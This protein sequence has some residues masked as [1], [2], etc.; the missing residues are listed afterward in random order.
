MRSEARRREVWRRQLRSLRS[1]LSAT[2]RRS[3]LGKLKRD[4]TGLAANSEVESELRGSFCGSGDFSESSLRAMKERRRRCG[5]IVDEY[6]Y[7][8]R[9]GGRF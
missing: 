8:K 5:T 2:T 1:R 7:R 4:G 9:G 3:S 6:W